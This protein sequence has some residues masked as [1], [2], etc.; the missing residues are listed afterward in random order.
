MDP[1]TLSSITKAV[2]ETTIAATHAIGSAT[3]RGVT[4]A[5]ERRRSLQLYLRDVAQEVGVF[6]TYRPAAQPIEDAFV[7]PRL[8]DGAL[9][10]VHLEPIDLT[11]IL[12]KLSPASSNEVPVMSSQYHQAIQRKT[13]LLQLQFVKVQD[14]VKQG[15]KTLVLGEAGAGKSAL[16]AHLC[17]QALRLPKPRVPVFLS[18][19]DLYGTGLEQHLSAI[20]QRLGFPDAS[21]EQ[22]N[23]LL[24]IYLDGLDEL[25]KERY[26]QICLEIAATCRRY[27]DVPL[28]ACCRSAYYEGELDFLRQ[29]SIAPF[30]G[31]ASEEFIRRWFRPVKEGPTADQLVATLRKSERL[32]ELATQPLLLA[33][34]CNAF[35]RYLD[36]SRRLTTLFEQCANAF[37][38]QWDADRVVKRISAF[39]SLDLQKRLWLHAAVA[40]RLHAAHLR[41]MR[42]S[43]ALAILSDLLPN[44]G[45]DKPHAEQVLA[46]MCAHHGL[47]VRWTAD[48][49]AFGHLALQ[50]FFAGK[51]LSDD[52]RWRESIQS[53]HAFDPWWR[54][55]VGV[56]IGCLSDA[57]SA[58]K[59]ILA[60]EGRTELERYAL[61]AHCLKY[62]PIL[63]PDTREHIVMTVLDW[64]HNGDAAKHDAAVSMLIGIEDE[65]AARQ[66]RKSLAGEPPT[67]ATARLFQ[68]SGSKKRSG[69][70]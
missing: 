32:V 58:I 38:W 30:D 45:I 11:R 23:Q 15:S 40:H 26:R 2:L 16:L 27:P 20:S 61:A 34:M 57:T 62:D 48:T 56:T 25:P 66:I 64:Y 46:E 69:E 68:R 6:T 70:Q 50:E 47:L 33:L 7:T 3:F 14:I 36:F 67:N 51:W 9:S 31:P 41:M 8:I 54:N 19:R 28:V 52:G 5:R 22:L 53:E 35:R 65:W 44:F 21:S 18:S 10:R 4:N 1:V 12:S 37:L 55:V 42:K 17:W 13:L 60:L 63:E 39:A 49:Y 43:E 59:M 29:V 24:S